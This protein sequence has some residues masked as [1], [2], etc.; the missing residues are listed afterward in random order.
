VGVIVDSGSVIVE[1]NEN[2]NSKAAGSTTNI[3]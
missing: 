2:N 1:T 3:K